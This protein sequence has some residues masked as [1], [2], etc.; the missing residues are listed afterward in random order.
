M[1]SSPIDAGPSLNRSLARKICCLTWVVA[2]L[3]SCGPP[4][5]PRAASAPSATAPPTAAN[6]V[7]T[8][9]CGSWSGSGSRTSQ[10]VTEQ[11]GEIRNCLRVNDVWVLTTLGIKGGP[12]SVGLDGCLN[13]DSKC[14]DGVSDHPYEDWRFY[15]A[16]H[17][18][19]VTVI[20]RDN[21][22]LMVD[23]GGYQLR[24]DVA[25]ATFAG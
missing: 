10:L 11:Y 17:S 14:L 5:S 8:G 23:N 9:S 3:V 15:R 24:F 7:A 16:P 4:P 2:L 19:A 1:T 13:G 6:S 18:G 12:G 25:N 20:G 22:T 21:T